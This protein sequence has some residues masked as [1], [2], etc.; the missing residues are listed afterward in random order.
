MIAD[1]ALDTEQA[2]VNICSGKAFMVREIAK[3][4][5]DEYGRRDL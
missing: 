4:I 5:A 1:V 2:P 3:L